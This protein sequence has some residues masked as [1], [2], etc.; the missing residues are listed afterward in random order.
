MMRL[1]IVDTETTGPDTLTDKIVT[2]FYGV[3]DEQG[4]MVEKHSFLFN[5][6]VAIPPE[7][8]QIHG[9]SDEIAKRD[10]IP[11]T[12]HYEAFSA[13]SNLLN[14]HRGNLPVVAYNAAFDFSIIDTTFKRLGLPEVNKNIFVLDPFVLDKHYDFYRSGSRSQKTVSAHYGI[15]VDETLIH[16]A[17]YDCY[18]AGRITQE[19]LKK[20]PEILSFSK[21][22]LMLKQ[23]EWKETHNQKLQNFLR[24][25]NNDDTIVVKRGWPV[26]D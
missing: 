15:E 2:L 22:E 8:E 26:Y 20:Y 10:G 13:I 3:M 17:E 5:P 19:L 1:G 4:E 18:L 23:A 12:E 16:N 24:N 9:I 25:V 7:A 11:V 21:E 6:G 14:R